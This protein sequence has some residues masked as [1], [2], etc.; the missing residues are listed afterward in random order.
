MVEAGTGE[1]KNNLLFGSSRIVSQTLDHWREML[2]YAFKLIENL[3]AQLFKSR[4]D[5]RQAL[6]E[7]EK[8]ESECINAELKLDQAQDILLEAP[9]A[10]NAMLKDQRHNLERAFEAAIKGLRCRHE[11][12]NFLQG[13]FHA[14][15]ARPRWRG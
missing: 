12:K 3:R 5:T 14:S 1:N 2:D 13:C 8:A 7:K 9:Q 15:L 10:M 6:C 4:S 11:G